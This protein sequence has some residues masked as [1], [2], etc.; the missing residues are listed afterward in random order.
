VGLS[1]YLTGFAFRCVQRGFNLISYKFDSS[2]RP[3]ERKSTQHAINNRNYVRNYD[4]YQQIPN[5]PILIYLGQGGSTARNFVSFCFLI[6]IQMLLDIPTPMPFSEVN[7]PLPS[8]EEEWSA[9][10]AEEWRS[11]HTSTTSPPTPTFNEAFDSLFAGN[12]ENIHRYSE[13]GGYVMISGILSAILNTYRISMTP[14][15]S[16]DWRKFDISIDAW[17]RSWNA[18]PKSYSIGPR[19]PFSTMAFNASAIYRATTILRVRDY[20][21][22]SQ[23]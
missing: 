13:F 14:A 17:Q 16:I 8:S 9:N 3:F 18:D 6:Q 12:F 10:S 19:N 22:S 4:S 23:I 15:V 1:V 2:W 7:L 21:K 20:S 11:I 5:S